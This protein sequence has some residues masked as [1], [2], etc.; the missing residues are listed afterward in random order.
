MFWAFV[1]LYNA[2]WPTISAAKRGREYGPLPLP[3]HDV[4]RRAWNRR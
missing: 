4:W 2:T 1:L 3:E